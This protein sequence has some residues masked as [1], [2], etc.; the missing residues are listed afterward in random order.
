MQNIASKLK[1]IN[2]ID[3]IKAFGQMIIFVLKS[4]SPQ[5]EVNEAYRFELEGMKVIKLK[6]RI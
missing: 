5:L 3:V 2:D 1:S 4:E 6:E